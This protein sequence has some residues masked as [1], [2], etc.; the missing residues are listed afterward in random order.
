VPFALAAALSAALL[1]GLGGAAGP[2]AADNKP[3]DSSQQ[4][5]GGSLPQGDGPVDLDDPVDLDGPAD[6]AGPGDGAPSGPAQ[7]GGGALPGEKPTDSAPG[8]DGGPR[9]YTD[10]APPVDPGFVDN[11]TRLWKQ[12]ERGKLKMRSLGE[13]LVA[14]RQVLSASN[15][16]LLLAIRAR[17]MA[18]FQ[19]VDAAAQFDLAV[20]DMYITGTTDV[21][22]I[23]GVLGSKPDDVLRTI[24][25]VVYLRSATGTESAD[26]DFASSASVIAQSAAASVM[27]QAE[28][29]RDRVDSVRKAL[30]KTKKEL[31]KDQR[32]LKRLV[33]V[34]APQ[35]VV[36]NNGCPKEVLEGTVPEGV[37]IK[38][39]CA[40][41]VRTAAS[42]Q[43]AFA[44]KW[45]LVRVGAPYACE[46]IGRLEAWRFDCSSF[47]S[48]AYAEGA[49]LRTAGN[50]WAPSTR[51]MVP[52]DGASLDPHYA[53]IDP[54]DIRPGDLVLYDTCPA[55]EVCPYRHVVMYLGAQK[56][57]GPEM[58]VHT[59][60]CGSVA[61]VAPFTGL[62]AANLL[63]VRR[64]IPASGEKIIGK[65]D[66]PKQAGKDDDKPKQDKGDDKPKKPKDD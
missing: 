12:V 55:G 31:T 26:F 46:G 23:L 22:V 36:G 4:D 3:D 42:P 45:A 29:D 8:A 14:A 9:P 63:G 17:N 58:M 54:K 16:D 59:N 62:D 10:A 51:N 40:V 6:G 41:A 21:D 38:Q 33:A 43:A 20:K 34:A 24:D 32:E 60:S 11:Y 48:R 44:I 64:V 2:V 49:G 37:K 5:G 57:G 7:Q 15:S 66:A 52:W 25:S 1:G 65:V 56:G 50:G 53:V 35:T 19:F 13:D 61:H 39:L 30:K 18:D 27:I 28:Q 47:V